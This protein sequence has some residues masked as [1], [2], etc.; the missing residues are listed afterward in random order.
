[1]RR[2]IQGL[3]AVAVMA[4]VLFH[5]WP[6]RLPGGYIGV[7]VFFVISGFLITSLMLREVAATGRVRLAAFWARR[8]RRLLPASYVVLVATAVGVWLWVPTLHWQQYFKEVGAA[9][10]YV[11]NWSLA[12][13]SVDY[14]AADNAPSP[15]QHY[16]TLSAEEQF[17]IVWPLLVLLGALLARRWQARRGHSGGGAFPRAPI[18]VVL[19]VLTLGSLAYSL[20]ESAANPEAASFITPTRAWEFGA[21]AM[22]AFVPEARDGS[23]AQLRTALSWVGLGVIAGACLVLSATTPMPGTAAVW[24]VMATAGV[25]WAGDPGTLWSPIRVLGLRPSQY[26]GDISYAMYLWHWPLLILAPYVAVTSSLDLRWRLGVIVATIVLSGLSTTYVEDPVRTTRRWG[27]PRPAVSLGLAAAGSAALVAMGSTTWL[28]MERRNEAEVQRVAGVL[29]KPAVCFGAASRDPSLDACPDPALA[30]VLIPSA[31]TA[32]ADYAWYPG[33]QERLQEENPLRGCPLGPRHEGV[34]RVA[35]IGDS[36]ARSLAPM[37][38]EL[39]TQGLITADLF[40]ASGCTWSSRTP[41]NR[42]AY[43]EPCDNLNRRFDALLASE[44]DRHDAIITTSYGRLMGG[45]DQEQV[46]GLLDVWRPVIASGVRIVAVRDNPTPLL[47]RKDLQDCISR[48]G[49]SQ[50][51]D[52]CSLD[53]RKAL[54]SRFDAYK[55]AVDQ[56]PGAAFIDMSR[57]FCDATTCPVVIGGVDVYRDSNHV[58]VTFQNS[59]APYY[60]KALKDLGL[61]GAAAG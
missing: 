52:L 28:V 48:V 9:A 25:I 2:E 53:R 15:V 34:P 61:L 11:E 46:T 13:D 19:G 5:V 37:I 42:P 56:A 60:A 44:P 32:A 27:I 12:A 6:N 20:Y 22:L 35:L 55:E 1:V 41:G 59:L 39:D 26:L 40:T 17:Y 14:L 3:R 31:D 51:N 47:A 23:A 7:D 30:S 16:W 57:F 33:C 36:H 58:T 43:R 21:G 8:A 49:V 38:E 50:I 29:D 24:V 18:A 54:D 45:T 10:H 4:V